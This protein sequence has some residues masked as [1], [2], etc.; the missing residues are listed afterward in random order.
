MRGVCK[1]KP[2][3]PRRLMQG[4]SVPAWGTSVTRRHLESR[5]CE[6]GNIGA[7]GE[8]KSGEP[9]LTGGE[10]GLSGSMRTTGAGEER[11]CLIVSHA[12]S[13]INHSEREMS[14]CVQAPGHF[15]GIEGSPEG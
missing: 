4:S 2:R 12:G 10:P 9:Q 5:H 8:R 3:I 6:R 14:R 11:H 7:K 15:W 13:D 1:K